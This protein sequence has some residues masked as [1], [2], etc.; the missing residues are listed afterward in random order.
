MAKFRDMKILGT[1]LLG[2]SIPKRHLPNFLVDVHRRLAPE[3][4][5]RQA[6]SL[7]LPSAV[8][9]YELLG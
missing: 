5:V 8:C 9:V 3:R 1:T 4:R 6:Q 7:E 2:A